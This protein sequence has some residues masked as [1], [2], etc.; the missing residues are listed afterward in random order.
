MAAWGATRAV[1]GGLGVL[2]GGALTQFLAWQWIFLINLP[3]GILAGIAALV[4]VPV[5]PGL[6]GSRSEFDFG[7]AL[8]VTA[9]ITLL[10]MSIVQTNTSGW[11][12]PRTLAYLAGSLASL[13]A[14]AWLELR[15][16]APLVPLGRLRNRMLIS[17]N[18]VLSIAYGLMT[19]ML[20]FVSLYVQTVLHF[21]PFEGG[22][23][24]I[25]Y[26]ITAIACALL[27]ERTAP[28]FGMRPFLI[29]GMAI[30]IAGVVLL[31]QV[32]PTG[33][34]LRDVLPGIAL[35][36][37]GNGFI[38]GNFTLIANNCLGDDHAGLASGL[39]NTATQIGAVLGVAVFSTIGASAAHG[40]ANPLVG[41]T[42]GLS[43][44]FT[45][46]AV[47]LGLT[48]VAVTIIFRKSVL[49]NMAGGAPVAA[50]DPARFGS[51]RRAGSAFQQK[52]S[53]AVRRALTLVASRNS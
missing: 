3:I 32:S 23:S 46:T 6:G 24:Y 31:A 50:P 12:G 52:G 5:Q 4:F 34:Y 17:S 8:T 35:L 1:A 40:A 42:D 39:Y 27:S 45:L 30:T 47:I 16:H 13:A 29:A 25:P 26:F 7:G 43:A 20:F 18:T 49:A 48:L 44:A 53:T 15:H 36:G 21:N 2:I 33:T 14:F 9:G 22:A 28:R 38:Y 37:A 11:L 19:G 51:A 41:L 10:A